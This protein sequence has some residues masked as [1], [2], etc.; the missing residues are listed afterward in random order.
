MNLVP[1]EFGMFPSGGETDGASTR[2][3]GG[4]DLETLFNR[5]TKQI[6]HHLDH[7]LVCVV[8]VV[9]EYHMVTWLPFAG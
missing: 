4:S 9:P 2:V 6:P 3:Y 8:I 5:M 1:F 7:V